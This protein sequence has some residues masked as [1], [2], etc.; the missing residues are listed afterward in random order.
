[1]FEGQLSAPES[2][3]GGMWLS[4]GLLTAMS[5]NALGQMVRDRR[6]FTNCACDAVSFGKILLRQ[7]PP[8]PAR[9]GGGAAIP[10]ADRHRRQ[11]RRQIAQE[12]ARQER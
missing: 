5:L 1:M 7:P 6:F 2:T 8:E 3:W 9:R 12:I 4:G 11:H 10:E